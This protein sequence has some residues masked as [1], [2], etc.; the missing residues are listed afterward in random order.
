MKI[1]ISQLTGQFKGKLL[2]E[3]ELFRQKLLGTKAFVFDWDGVFN[4]GF[5]DPAGSSSFS[6][7]DAMGT[8]LLRFNHFLRESEIPIVA[9]L[10]GEKNNAAFV[11]A[12][13][14]HIQAVYYKI[15]SKV[16]ALH[17]LCQYYDVKPSQ[18]AFVFD[19]VL[20][21]AAAAECGLRFML[22][23]ACNPQLIDFACRQGLVDYTT[24]ADGG[25]HAVREITELL[26][27]VSGRF[28]QTIKER[29]AFSD[30]YKQYLDIRNKPE[31][32]FFTSGSEMEITEQL[33]I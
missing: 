20:D 28:D 16:Q 15:G 32:F 11:F 5:K 12:R 8:N 27:V 4:N 2:I 21:F 29:M 14:E 25:H 17:H 18:V 26:M 19:D 30:L 22:S 6:E 23:R 24:A 33:P 9:I 1:E 3:E 10:S 13:R 31:P 7:V